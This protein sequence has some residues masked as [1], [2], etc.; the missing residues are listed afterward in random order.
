MDAIFGLDFP[1]RLARHP[2]MFCC[3]SVFVL[4]TS[5]KDDAVNRT[6]SEAEKALQEAAAVAE[7]VEVLQ[8]ELEKV[9]LAASTAEREHA[10]HSERMHEELKRITADAASAER[11][12][13]RVEEL[14]HEMESTKQMAAAAAEEN[15]SRTDDLRQKLEAANAAATSAAQKN[16]VLRQ[17][18][19]EAN[20]MAA[21]A[22]QEKAAHVEGLRQDLGSLNA[23]LVAAHDNASTS[24]QELER[25]TYSLADAENEMAAM[26]EAR[27]AAEANAERAEMVRGDAETQLEVLRQKL[28]LA[29]ASAGTVKTDVAHG[30]STSNV[31]DHEAAAATQAL[32]EAREDVF[33]AETMLTT[34]NQAHEELRRH[35][36]K[37]ADEVRGLEAHLS[38]AKASST[39]LEGICQEERAALQKSDV[40]VNQLEKRLAA[41]QAK[42]DGENTQVTRASVLAARRA[43]AKTS[44]CLAGYPRAAAT[45]GHFAQRVV[46]DGGRMV[47]AAKC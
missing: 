1:Q 2:V 13:S 9:T 27:I 7:R 17:E 22:E 18:L 39:R 5:E 25:A 21:L 42:F 34:A 12:A 26:N 43:S 45:R 8:H 35:A 15:A 47:A 28:S 16:E 11:H 24:Q 44:R 36:A 38:E 46:W 4:H 32:Q 41:L 6:Q 40:K 3:R 19:T 20:A 23:A 33:R 37:L 29:D 31:A 10:A 14:C 30:D